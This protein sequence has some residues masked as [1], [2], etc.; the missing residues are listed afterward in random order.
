MNLV[1]IIDKFNLDVTTDKNSVHSYITG[2]YENEFLKYKN[3]KI[4]ILEVGVRKGGSI[5]LWSEYFTKA[6][7]I[8]GID[9][10][11]QDIEPS[12]NTIDRVKYYFGDAYTPE[13]ANEIP[14]L[15]IFVDDGPHTL[16]SQI[17]AIKYYLP[18]IKL[19]GVFIIEDVQNIDWFNFF[20]EEVEIIRQKNS[21]LNYE[22]EHVD[23]RHLKNK[24]GD[25]RYDKDDLIFV[26]RVS[27]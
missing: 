3:K 6:N 25:Y 12:F 5:K 1:E 4:T 15:N 8:I 2:F 17:N 16:K 26:V 27:K 18:K 11:P 10:S 7:S 23:L 21:K 24:F 14:K 13:I 22:I 9:V 19:G 20:D